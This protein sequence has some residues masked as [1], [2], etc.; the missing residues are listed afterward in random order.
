MSAQASRERRVVFGEVAE[1]YDEMRPSYP[2]EIFDIVMSYGS[3]SAGDDALEIGA[4]TGKA[5]ADVL[6]RGLC[7]HA[8]EPSPGMA[9][10]LRG[11][12]VDVEETTFETFEPDRAYSL[13]YA[14]QSWH[15]VGG[16]DRYERVAR[17]LSRGGT[18]ALFWNIGRPHPEPF[19]TDNDAVYER[20]WPDNETDAVW[21][22]K[23][24]IG[25]WAKCD[26]FAPLETHVVTWETEYTT[27]E[28]IRF[29]GTHSNHRMLP[30][31][32]RK[33]VHDGVAAAIDKHGG[34][35][36]VVYDTYL[37]LTRRL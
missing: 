17:C 7:V 21:T 28:W 16:D 26:K 34:V 3:L 33:Q 37:Y 6:A 13:V 4:G 25:D 32:L 23:A 19:K 31:D 35:V 8:L 15:W 2:K 36:P 10:L 18:V 12:G 5:T 9:A 30:D 27:E 11:K 29:L 22:G 20:L 24:L 1:L 14:A